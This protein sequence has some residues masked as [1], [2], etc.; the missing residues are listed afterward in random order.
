MPLGNTLRQVNRRKTWEFVSRPHDES[1]FFI[2]NINYVRDNNQNWYTRLISFVWVVR[3]D[4]DIMFN[5]MQEMANGFG[6]VS[7]TCLLKTNGCMFQLD[8]LCQYV[9][10]SMYYVYNRLT[11]QVRSFLISILSCQIVNILSHGL[12]KYNLNCRQHNFGQC[13]LWLSIKI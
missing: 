13:L 8:S 2:C 12:T 11:L 6:L 9:Y 3:T 4:N 5:I 7:R 10:T 1:Y